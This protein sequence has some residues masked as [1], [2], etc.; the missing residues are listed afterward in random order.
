MRFPQAP[1]SRRL[2]Q[3]LDTLDA[4][5][6]QAIL[7]TNVARNPAT[8][9]LWTQHTIRVGSFA[10]VRWYEINPVPAVP[11]ILRTGTLS[12]ATIHFFN[13]AISSDRRRDG[14]TGQFGGSFVVGY[15]VSSSTIPVRIQMGSSVNGGAF[16]NSIVFSSPGPYRDFACAG[17]GATCRWGDYAAATPDPRPTTPANTG[18]V[19]LTTQFASGDIFTSQSNW[20][21]LIWEARP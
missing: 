9:S 14:A 1:P 11:V 21:T 15:N 12:S 17:S 4:R 3:L 10:G 13:A 19:A 5:N 20:R 8:F 7:A 16:T 2:T 18:V 6:T